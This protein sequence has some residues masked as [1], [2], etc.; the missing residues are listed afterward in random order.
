[1][2]AIEAAKPELADV[3]KTLKTTFAV[4]GG[5]YKDTTGDLNLKTFDGRRT[6]I[7]SDLHRVSETPVAPVIVW[8]V[9]GC[10]MGKSGARHSFNCCIVSVSCGFWIPVWPSGNRVKARLAFHG[11][12]SL[13]SHSLRCSATPR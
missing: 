10:A 1:M 7:L 13:V 3:I 2:Y 11:T 8:G 9:G 5:R 6:F 4:L 12:V